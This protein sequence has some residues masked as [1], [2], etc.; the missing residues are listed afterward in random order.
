MTAN[1]EEVRQ[2]VYQL[3]IIMIIVLGAGLTGRN[4]RDVYVK[5]PIGT[6]V[7]EK[8]SDDFYEVLVREIVCDEAMLSLICALTRKRR[9]TKMWNFLQCDWINL[10]K[11][12]RSW[13][14]VKQDSVTRCCQKAR[15]SDPL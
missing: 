9:V 6:A 14:V 3:S 13:R 8:V 12:C 5:V 1:T 15:D 4:G 11:L 2:M 10:D 7:S